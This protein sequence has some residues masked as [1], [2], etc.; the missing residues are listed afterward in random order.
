MI[1]HRAKPAEA[2]AFVAEHTREDWEHPVNLL[3]AFRLKTSVSCLALS[4]I[5]DG[6]PLGEW[7]IE[8]LRDAAAQLRDE[9]VSFCDRLE[10]VLQL[11]QAREVLGHEDFIRTIREEC[12]GAPSD[13]R[14]NGAST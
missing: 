1:T 11:E 3:L 4:H 14:L 8:G 5:Q 2:R 7:E 9:V 6:E 10:T 12:G 13:R